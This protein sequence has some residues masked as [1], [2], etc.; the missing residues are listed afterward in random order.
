MNDESLSLMDSMLA[1]AKDAL[2]STKVGATA[3]VATIA[4]GIGTVLEWMPQNVGWMASFAGLVYMIFMIWAL[5]KRS[6][7]EAAEATRKKYAD[8]RDK[9][10]HEM[11]MRLAEQDLNS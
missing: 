8:K 3:G 4:T 5:V 11:D 7:Y 2:I 6:K 1:T 9:E 10:R